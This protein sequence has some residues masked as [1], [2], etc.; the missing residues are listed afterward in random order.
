MI[1][2]LKVTMSQEALGGSYF[3]DCPPEARCP[4]PGRRLGY[5]LRQAYTQVVKG[6]DQCPASN[7]V[8]NLGRDRAIP[9]PSD[10]LKI[11]PPKASFHVTLGQTLI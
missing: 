6:W 5:P 2:I 11:R 1:E 3:E 4:K 7:E 10:N 8:R 9:F